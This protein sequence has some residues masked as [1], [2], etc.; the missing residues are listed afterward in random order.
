M[1]VRNL[2]D[3]NDDGT[4]F[5]QDASDKITFFGGTA[6]VQDAFDNAAV[7]TTLPVSSTTTTGVY[8]FGSTQAAAIIALVNELRAKVVA[9]NLVA[10]A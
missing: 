10:T 3:Y 2:T 4:S 1:T 7:A 9:L 6:A 8:G 5:G